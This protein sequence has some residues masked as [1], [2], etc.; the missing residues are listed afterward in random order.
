MKKIAFLFPGQGSQ[1]VGMGQDIYQEFDLVREIFDMASEIAKIN[2]SKLCFKGP[3]EE[4]TQTVN[5]QPAITAVNLG[6]LSILQ[7]ESLVEEMSAG[8]SLSEYSALC[9]GGA[10]SKED[11]IRLVI[12][13]G[14]LMH[15]EAVQHRGAMT[16]IV[17]LPIDAVQ[18]IVD[19]VQQQG[20]VSVANHNTETQ[21]V[22]TGAPDPVAKVSAR[23]EEQG[24]RA[25]P[26]TVSGAWHSEMMRGAQ[27]EFRQYLETI[28]FET[29]ERSVV[30][31]VTADTEENPDEI[32]EIMTKQLCS[33]VKWYDSMQKMVDEEIEI[34]AEVGPGRVLSG[35]AKKILPVDYPAEIFTVNNMKT[36]EKFLS[37]AK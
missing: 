6:M 19:G 37:A 13:R 8:H 24:A 29:P 36:L 31:N 4:L 26:L 9:A 30:M 1:S 27:D 12:K 11:T 18:E 15:R 23:A 33:P 3:M 16:A 2:L 20:I 35:L 32:R 34:F 5:L 22:I 14:E 17:G 28:P 21:I 7:K 25:I 10:I